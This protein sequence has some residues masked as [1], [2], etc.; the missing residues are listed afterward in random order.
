MNTSRYRTCKTRLLVPSIQHTVYNMNP[1]PCRVLELTADDDDGVPNNNTVNV[2]TQIPL[3]ILDY[4]VDA[5]KV[6]L[7]FSVKSR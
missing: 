1:I 4:S 5:R 6:Y 2:S 7:I 3:N